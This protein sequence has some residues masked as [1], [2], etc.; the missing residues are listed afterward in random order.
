MKKFLITILGFSFF[1][2]HASSKIAE[3]YGDLTGDAIDERVVVTQL[4]K[5]NEFGFVRLLEVFIKSK[6]NW[7][8]LASSEN[9]IYESE[10]GGG[11]GDSFHKDFIC[12][13]DSILKVYHSGGEK[14][15][16]ESIHS[17][18]FANKRFEYIKYYSKCIKECEYTQEYTYDLI[19]GNVVFD[20][21]YQKCKSNNGL[22]I[23]DKVVHEEFNNK[24]KQKF[25]FS[26]LHLAE[27]RLLTPKHKE[28]V[29]Y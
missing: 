15:Q 8:L 20:K 9:I 5:K 21:K 19:T 13:E 24:P 25:N 29:Y 22:P 11:L 1:Q 12:I 28:V 2:L 23:C 3:I 14:W 10:S 6:N 4:D 17:Y 27:R 18:K 7:K 26:N 16:W